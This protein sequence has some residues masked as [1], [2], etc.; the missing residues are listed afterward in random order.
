MSL[1]INEIN[2]RI[3]LKIDLINYQTINIKHDNQHDPIKR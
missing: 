2:R 3:V 1:K